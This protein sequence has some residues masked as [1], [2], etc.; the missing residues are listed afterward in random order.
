MTEL[1]ICNMNFAY[2]E[3]GDMIKASKGLYSWDFTLD[4]KR[5]KIDLT[6]SRIKGKRTVACDGQDINTCLIY[7]YN[8]TYSF[9]LDGHYLTLIQISPDQYDLRIDN[10][11]FMLLK[12]KS[13]YK[14]KEQEK[15]K[16]YDNDD[17]Y[18]KKKNDNDDN[19]FFNDAGGFDFGD[20]N[21]NNNKAEN[22]GDIAND[23][24]FGD[25]DD[26]KEKKKEK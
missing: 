4:G 20:N 14:R 13:R 5:H 17:D 7:T 10:I 24:D 15:K 21:N 3:I 2:S 23:F 6:H 16:N 19:N 22:F 25:D 12:N 9:P 8:Y 18:D 1:N 11:S 26:K